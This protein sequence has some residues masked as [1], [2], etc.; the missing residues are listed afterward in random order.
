MACL[1]TVKVLTRRNSRSGCEG[2]LAYTEVFW[3]RVAKSPLLSLQG[4][5]KH[6]LFIPTQC[7]RRTFGVHRRGT[8]QSSV[9]SGFWKFCCCCLLFVLSETK[10]KS[11]TVVAQWQDCGVD[12]LDFWFICF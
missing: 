9:Q 5:G 10:D 11:L 12:G 1:E 4:P 6:V 7:D 2:S 3:P 8:Q